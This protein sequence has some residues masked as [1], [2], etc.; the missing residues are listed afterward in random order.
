MT[1]QPLTYP[2]LRLMRGVL[3][4]LALVAAGGTWTTSVQAQLP[5]IERPPAKDF[6]FAAS[7][8]NTDSL[9]AAFASDITQQAINLA[10]EAAPEVN[11]I[12][13]EAK[14]LFQKAVAAATGTTPMDPAVRAR[15]ETEA[16]A[17]AD[18]VSEQR[19]DKL[20]LKQTQ[21]LEQWAE[22]TFDSFDDAKRQALLGNGRGGKKGLL[23]MMLP[24]G[25]ALLKEKIR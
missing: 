10:R 9:R 8:P 20:I 23:A 16:K 6:R 19:F 24:P 7:V 11:A 21:K 13:N 25:R 17:K 14:G 4:I 5:V 1:A 3:A 2:R 15:I 22:S 12:H 18:K